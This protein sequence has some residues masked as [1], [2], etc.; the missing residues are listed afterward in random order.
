LLVAALTVDIRL[1]DCSSLKEKRY[2]LSGIKTRLR[3]KFNLAVSEI[4]FHDKWQRSRLALVTVGN[5][6][7]FLDSVLGRAARI[8]ELERKIEILDISTEHL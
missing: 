4:D 1:R 6:G 5:D 8:L 2:I 3:K 7:S